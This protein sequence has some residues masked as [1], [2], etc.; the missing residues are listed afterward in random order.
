MPLNNRGLRVRSEFTA[1][2]IMLKK[3]KTGIY[4]NL[5]TLKKEGGGGDV[6][7]VAYV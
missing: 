1:M 4:S 2:D 5:K 7:I 3:W 6:K